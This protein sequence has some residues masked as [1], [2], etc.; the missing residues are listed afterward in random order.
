MDILAG[1]LEAVREA[2]RHCMAPAVVRSREDMPMEEAHRIALVAAAVGMDMLKE[3]ALAWRIEQVGRHRMV[4]S[5]VAQ[6]C[7]S[8]S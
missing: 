1:I 7:S 5:K 6:G 8:L 3:L 4:C 2:V